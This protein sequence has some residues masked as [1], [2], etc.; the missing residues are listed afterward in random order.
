MV[1]A[2]QVVGGR[3]RN[4]VHPCKS[5]CALAFVMFSFTEIDY[6]AGPNIPLAALLPALVLLLLNGPGVMAIA[7]CGLLH[8]GPHG[9]GASKAIRRSNLYLSGCDRLRDP[10]S[11]GRSCMFL[12]DKSGSFCTGHSDRRAHRPVLAGRIDFW[13]AIF[14]ILMS[15][16]FAPIVML[17]GRGDP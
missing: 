16:I 3:G 12:H 7:A 1:I 11:G 6:R 5:T 4:F 2:E 17:R 13:A 14:A 10:L 9:L 15:S 8:D